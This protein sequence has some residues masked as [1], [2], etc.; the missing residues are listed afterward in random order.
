VLDLS[1]TSPLGRR[2]CAVLDMIL[3]AAL[4]RRQGRDER[5]GSSGRTK[6]WTKVKKGPEIGLDSARAH[7]IPIAH[8]APPPNYQS[9]FRALV[10]LV[11]VP[12][13]AQLD[14]QSPASK[15]LHN[16]RLM[17][18][19][20]WRKNSERSR[21]TCSFQQ[22]TSATSHRTCDRRTHRQLPQRS[23][24]SFSAVKHLA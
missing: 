14:S 21:R 24:I 20:E 10:L 12:S 4:R 13:S 5:M 6:E 3:R 7:I 18:R 1:R 2:Y 16:C 22:R 19:I 8:A 11:A 15:N 9:R 23:V 17:R